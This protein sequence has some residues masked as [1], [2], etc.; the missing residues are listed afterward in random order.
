[1]ERGKEFYNNNKK[2]C[3]R[4]AL[5]SLCLI[6]IGYFSVFLQK[7]IYHNDRF[8]RETVKGDIY[9]YELSADNYFDLNKEEDIYIFTIKTLEETETIKVEEVGGR[10]VLY[11]PENKVYI[12]SYRDG[13][14]FGENGEFDSSI[15]SWGINIKNQSL[16]KK[17]PKAFVIS[18]ITRDRV[19]FRGDAE[20]L[21]IA[22]ILLVVGILG[23]KYPKEME[24]WGSRWKFK[25][26]EKVELTEE[27]IFLGK[28]ACI[29]SLIASLVIFVLGITKM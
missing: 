20:A 19:R 29:I 15:Y 16:D 24:F 1:M 28:V 10:Y 9:K 21:L 13:H 6:V 18:I 7:G 4:I 8:Y 14:F 26:Y 17:Y 12:G 27:Y 5:I 11:Y 3:N 25:N 23:L 2:L 22:I